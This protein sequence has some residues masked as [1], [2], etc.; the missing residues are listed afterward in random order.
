[1]RPSDHRK[2]YL[3]SLIRLVFLAGLWALSLKGVLE[4]C[5]ASSEAMKYYTN[6][7]NAMV[8]LMLG[9]Q[10][11]LCIINL[12]RK[13]KEPLY[14]PAVL[15][16]G[17][18]LGILITFLTYWGVLNNFLPP[19]SFHD[20]TVHYLVPLLTLA[21]FLLFEPHGRLRLWHPV[22]WL[23]APVAYYLFVVIMR[24]SD[25]YF[26]G[27]EYPYFFM[28]HAGNGWQYVVII[29][30]ILLAAFL[31]CGYLLWLIDRLLKPKK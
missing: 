1:M 13:E 23:S 2:K 28:D 16:G 20:A 8:V 9:A 15:K 3:F 21:E 29:S 25:E 27:R 18:V 22:A 24:L 6:L 7:S 31:A 30:L 4:A 14:I 17:A 11:V 10:L 12:L 26:D 5:I 19:H